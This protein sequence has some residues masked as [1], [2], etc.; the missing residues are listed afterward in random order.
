MSSVNHAD[1]VHEIGQQKTDCRSQSQ[2]RHRQCICAATGNDRRRGDKNGSMR[3]RLS[4]HDAVQQIRHF[5]ADFPEF[6]ADS[7]RGN[8]VFLLLPPVQERRVTHNPVCCRKKRGGINPASQ[9]TSSTLRTS[10]RPSSPEPSQTVFLP[11]HREQRPSPHHTHTRRSCTH[12]LPYRYLT[13][14]QP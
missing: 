12:T 7:C 11:E 14:A 6:T 13:P 8:P 10:G 5:S 3:D 9:R 1:E 2:V 4:N